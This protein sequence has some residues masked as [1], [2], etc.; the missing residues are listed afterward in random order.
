MVAE[1]LMLQWLVSRI[2]YSKADTAYLKRTFGG[3]LI[4]AFELF[5]NYRRLLNTLWLYDASGA[6]PRLIAHEDEGQCHVH[7][8]ARMNQSY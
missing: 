3:A 6:P 7:Q 2:E 4:L 8:P 1:A 5:H